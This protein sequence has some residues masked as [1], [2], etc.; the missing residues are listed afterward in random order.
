[1]EAMAGKD[2]S[3]G[4]CAMVLDASREGHGRRKKEEEG[5][6]EGGHQSGGRRSPQ[7][8]RMRMVAEVEGGK[9]LSGRL[10]HF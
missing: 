5:A 1:M 3:I 10:Q 7:W 4:R 6:D 9:P 2:G 8:G